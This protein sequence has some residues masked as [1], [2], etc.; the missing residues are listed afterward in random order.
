MRHSYSHQGIAYLVPRSVLGSVNL[1]KIFRVIRLGCPLF[2]VSAAL[3]K[4]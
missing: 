4:N 2:V 1:F 3:C